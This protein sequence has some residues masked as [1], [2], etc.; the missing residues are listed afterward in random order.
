MLYVREGCCVY[1]EGDLLDNDAKRVAALLEIAA[2]SSPV[3]V[4]CSNVR[5]MHASVL[6][7]F[8]SC[9]RRHAG[10]SLSIVIGDRKLRRIFELTGATRFLDVIS[11]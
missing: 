1:L 5:K 9:A 7:A 4:D 11:A 3:T 2:A 6:A 10:L 8:L